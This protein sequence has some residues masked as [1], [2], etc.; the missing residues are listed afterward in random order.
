MITAISWDE[1]LSLKV[2][3]IDNDH[4][5][6]ID[7]YNQ[8]LGACMASVG[9]SIINKTLVKLLDYT[10]EHFAREE[11]LMIKSHY[12]EIQIHK[13]EHA[14]LQQAVSNLRE[15]ALSDAS[16]KNHDISNDT[17]VFLHGWIVD[18][19]TSADRALARFLLSDEHQ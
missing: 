3:E 17:L 4:K 15:R 19:I 16:D 1:S 5:Q 10:N 13:S 2:P 14:T 18:H 8:L 11:A 7:Y 6:L 12:P 9:P